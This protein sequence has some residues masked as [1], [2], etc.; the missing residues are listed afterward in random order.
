VLG[1]RRK[2]EYGLLEVHIPPR[3]VPGAEL[4]GLVAPSMAG[5]GDV[6]FG[7]DKQRGGKGLRNKWVRTAAS[8]DGIKALPHHGD[9]GAAVHVCWRG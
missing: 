4:R 9:N 6:S 5:S 3:M 8:L 7:V 2:R 1:D